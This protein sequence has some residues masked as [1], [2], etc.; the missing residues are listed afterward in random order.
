M[1]KPTTKFGSIL[2]PIV[3]MLSFL[4][5][6]DIS[7][8]LAVSMSN[9]NTTSWQ[10]KLQAIM[11]VEIEFKTFLTGPP[12]FEV[13]LDHAGLDGEPPIPMHTPDP[14][15]LPILI[16]GCDIDLKAYFNM[17]PQTLTGEHDDGTPATPAEI[18]EATTD[19]ISS[20]AT[21]EIEG[22]L[23]VLCYTITP[24]VAGVYFIGILGFE[25]GIDDSAGKSFGFKVAMGLEVRAQWP[26]VGEVSVMMA[27]G[28]EMEW[29]DTGS[30]IFALIIFKGEAEL[31]GGLIV[32]GIGIEAKGGQEK[33]INS[34]GVTE[35]YAIVEVEFAVEVSL[36]FVIHFEFDETW[37][38]KRQTA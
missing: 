36:A 35:T 12:K 7:Q 22:E 18:D 33:E 15:P 26:V 25:F 30:G 20:G 11:G 29:S 32:I 6:Q 37:Q 14:E 4:G 5:G 10:P 13:K 28:L 2:Q 9:L 19:M 24:N 1:P 17:N 23:H 27:I 38:E 31:L 8:A 16:L 3:D 21:L 34:S